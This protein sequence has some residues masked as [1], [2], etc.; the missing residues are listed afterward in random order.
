VSVSNGKDRTS[1]EIIAR[2]SGPTTLKG[3]TERQAVCSYFLVLLLVGLASFRDYG[4]SW[5]E[6]RQRTIGGVSARYV[7]ETVAPS[8]ES[9]ATLPQTALAGFEDRDYGV[10]F[11]TPAVML[12]LFLGLTDTRAVYFMRHLLTYLVFLGGVFALYRMATR[13]FRD[14]R[15]GLFTATLLVLSPRFFAEAFYNS[16]DVVFMAMFAVATNTMLGFVIRP[17]ITS[18]LVHGLATAAAIDV[19]VVAVV[20]VPLTIG[21]IVVNLIK[22]NLVLRQA[23]LPCGLFLAST[24]VFV[25]LMFPWLW[26]DPVGRF[27]EAVQNMSNFQRFSDRVRY[28]GRSIMPDDLPW[29]YLPVWIAISTPILQLCLFVIGS[30]AVLRTVVSRHLRLWADDDQMQDFVFLILLC[31]PLVAIMSMDSVIYD[32]WR[33]VY[34]VYPSLLL[35]AARGWVYGRARLAVV[36][37]GPGAT[38]FARGLIPA[39]AAVSLG[40]TTAWMVGVHPM[41][42]VYFNWLAGDDWRRNYD[43]DYWGLANRA[44]LEY[45]L[46]HENADGFT[47]RAES[48]TPLELATLVL[49]PDERRRVRIVGRGDPAEY[50]LTNYRGVD[51]DEADHQPDRDLFYQLKV[52]DEVIVSIYKIRPL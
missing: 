28:M 45:V 11:E 43:L 12:E 14:W 18:A 24:A 9:T 20:L 35:I 10:V 7:L 41:Q 17:G 16:K 50:I 51:I 23:M 46:A 4:I 15:V 49:R 8:L 5:D 31:A 25:V 42:N 22:R 44:A 26:E 33:H 19:R 37:M 38:R 48:S 2:Q 47:I 40:T 3:P 13:R 52:D 34:F 27:L 29:H 36:R 39:L 6:P 1:L 32:G 21:L 30:V